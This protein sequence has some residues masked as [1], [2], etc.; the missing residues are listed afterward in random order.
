MSRLQLQMSNDER[1]YDLTISAGENGDLLVELTGVDGHGELIGELKGSLPAADLKLITRMLT[2]G[3][4][5]L[6]KAAAPAGPTL[7][8]RRAQHRNSHQ[9]WTEQ[10][11]QRLR[12]LAVAPG[13]NIRDLME[14]FGRSRSAIK[15]RLPRVGVH[16]ELP[17]RR[18]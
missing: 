7:E 16:E 3:A 15:A 17:T 2:T 9:P 13:A 18:P 11:D 5:T 14:A 12:E 10:D 1:T 8:E 4:V 6:K